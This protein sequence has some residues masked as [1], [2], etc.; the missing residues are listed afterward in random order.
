MM[1][2]L[3]DRIERTLSGGAD[4]LV[5]H[6][7]YLNNSDRIESQRVREMIEECLSRYSK[8]HRASLISRLR[9]R[10]DVMHL[11]ACFELI[12]H[13][14]FLRAGCS[15]DLPEQ[16]PNAGRAPDFQIT[17]PKGE[18][19]YLEAT[20]ATGRTQEEA[21]AGRR[22]AEA[23][24]AIDCVESPDLLLSVRSRGTPLK[25]VSGKRL[26]QR[27]C[28]W[29]GRLDYDAIASGA[30]VA[31]L[32]C[33][34]HGCRL[35]ISAFP[36]NRTRGAANRRAIGIY[37]GGPGYVQTREAIRASVVSK[38]TRYGNLDKPYVVAVNAMHMA[39]DE[40]EVV[41]ALLGSV[42][43]VV[44]WGHGAPA[45]EEERRNPDGAWYG[46]SGPLNTRVSA[47]LSTERLSFWS[48]G[49]RRLRLFHNP[50]TLRPLAHWPLDTDRYAPGDNELRRLP[51]N[52]VTGLFALP[53]GWPEVSS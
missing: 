51:G 46:L 14:L 21:A 6:F 29:L 33:E 11:S 35:E 43:V 41:E 5:S 42:S 45:I 19:F 8:S 24:R 53:E 50:W 52:S 25:P 13:D 31:P 37:G 26:K 28:E 20:L 15:V 47:V 3:F 36:R 34:E 1:H 44:R 17:T 30:G 32:I 18:S 48:L 49:Q 38:A 39:A 12:L 22:L 7:D 27:V 9:T 2:L 10:H 16:G 23:Y 40:H 4:G